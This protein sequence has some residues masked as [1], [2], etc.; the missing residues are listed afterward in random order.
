L[1]SREGKIDVGCSLPEQ[2]KSRTFF[3][4]QV[5]LDRYRCFFVNTADRFEQFEVVDAASDGDALTYA[6]QLLQRNPYTKAI[7]VWRRGLLI[8]RIDR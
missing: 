6:R 8:G 5:A 2:L 4:G 7:E 1:S 3:W